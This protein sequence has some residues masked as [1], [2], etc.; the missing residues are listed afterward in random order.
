MAGFAARCTTNGD[1]WAV[2]REYD[3]R[4]FSAFLLHAN[5][6]GLARD[7]HPFHLLL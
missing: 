1:W 7:W 5:A 2:G 3:D 4:V 6:G